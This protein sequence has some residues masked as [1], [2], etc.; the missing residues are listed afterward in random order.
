[1]SSSCSARSNCCSCPLATV[2]NVSEAKGALMNV[3][4]T[5]SHLGREPAS[6]ESIVA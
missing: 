4:A 3:D 1:M 2:A 5:S 6:L